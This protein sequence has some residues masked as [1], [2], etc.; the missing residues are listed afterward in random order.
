[1]TAVPNWT[2]CETLSIGSGESFRILET[3]T[4]VADELLYAGV[5]GVLV[6][7]LV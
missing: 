7:E 6:V 2:V 4:E 3:K 5:N 1:V